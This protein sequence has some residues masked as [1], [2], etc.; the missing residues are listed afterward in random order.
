[1]NFVLNSYFNAFSTEKVYEL[2]FEDVDSKL[3]SITDLLANS[4]ESVSYNAEIFEDLMDLVHGYKSMD[5]RSQKQLSYLVFSS[6]KIT[7]EQCA[8]SMAD[9]DFADLIDNYKACLERYSYMLYV[10]LTYLSKE[11]FSHLSATRGKPTN[12]QSASKWKSNCSQVV[13]GLDAISGALKLDLARIFITTS[14]RDLLMELFCRPIFNLMESPERMK[15]ANIRHL[16]F[17]DISILVKHHAY[18][19]VAQASILQCLLYYTHLSSYMA[20][21]LNTLDKIYHYN[22]LTEEVLREISQIEFNSNDNNGPKSVSEFLI[23]LSELCPR[24]ILKQM[25]YIAQLLDNSNQTLRCS[26]V[27]TCGNTIAYMLKEE[28]NSD[29]ERGN[30]SSSIESLFDLLEERFLDQNPYVRTKAIQAIT[31]ICS[32]PVKLPS[33]RQ[34]FVKLAVRSLDDKSTLVRRNA[35]KLLSKLILTHPFTAIHGTQLSYKFWKEKQCESEKEFSEYISMLKSSSHK[36]LNDSD[37]DVSDDDSVADINDDINNN[38]NDGATNDSMD[39]DDEK[40]GENGD[41]HTNQELNDLISNKD[42]TLPDTNVL[43]KAKLTLQYYSDAVDFIETI[44]HGA[45][46]ISR[47]LFS[48]NRN[49]VLEAMDFFV[50]ADAFDIRNSNDGIRRMLHLVWMKGSSDEGKSIA[51]H[52]V[53]CYKDLFLTVPADL[54]PVQKAAHIAKNLIELTYAGSAAD[55]ASLEK[56]LCLMYQNNYITNDVIKVLWLIYASSHQDDT[57]ND[58]QRRQQQR[59]AIVILGMLSAANNEIALKG[60][61]ALLNVGLGEAGRY[62]LELS[63]YTCIALQRMVPNLSKEGQALLYKNAREDEAIEKLKLVLLAPDSN[64]EYYTVLEQGLN[65]VYQISSQ[66][67]AVYSAIIRQRCKQ[68][69]EEDRSTVSRVSLLSL[70]LFI[71][72]HVALKTI[73]H[74]E[75]L[76]AD[77]KRKKQKV[78]SNGQEGNKDKQP[79]EEAELE[80]IGGTS[81]DDFADAVIYI[82]ERELLFGDGALLSKFGPLVKE[83]CANRSKYNDD[84]LQRSAV[85]CM[86]KLMCVSSKYCE[87]NLSLLITIMERSPDPIIRSNC[88]LGLGDMAVCFNQLVDENTDFLYRRLNDENIM[89]QRTCLMTVTFLILAGQVKVKGQ[90]SSMAK[91]LE[92]PDQ[93]I[94]DMCRLFFTELATKDNAIYNGFIDIFSGLSSDK[95]LDKDSMKRIVRFLVGF[96]EKEKQQ[97]QLSEK[98]LA[99]LSKAQSEEQWN[100]IAFVLGAIPFKNDLINKALED[101]YTFVKARQ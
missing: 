4:P 61:D 17:Q 74:L 27:E 99:R 23:K 14:E 51:S 75:K 37:N 40:N 6:L 29:Q 81:E 22:G 79:N 86:E 15:V 25:S 49:E 55:L 33:R 13:D 90:L 94:S 36:T 78:E 26:V 84:L 54:L 16:M 21:L 88:V 76:E 52:L 46:I 56:L 48:K 43:M 59:G 50:L 38:V 69:F 64:P 67:E 80:M 19:N 85:L 18:G 98:L 72:G 47:L 87:D 2:G 7:S 41:A 70:L 60:L 93:G 96:I 1:M 58:S 53:D 24:G 20:E 35:I 100:D 5:E 44:Q 65:A 62:D 97:K 82:K 12:S 57:N 28:E 30:S 92:N 45:E 71:V 101:G 32:L 95:S 89:V 77:F 68:V 91:C 3:G 63:K 39:V 11:D 9:N 73:I 42:V 34:V 31:K 66:P 83:I 10:I 8:H